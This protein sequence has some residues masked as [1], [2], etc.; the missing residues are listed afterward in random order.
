MPENQAAGNE[1]LPVILGKLRGGTGIS[2]QQGLFTCVTMPLA[3]QFP[4]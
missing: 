2:R 3:K 4:A 1:K